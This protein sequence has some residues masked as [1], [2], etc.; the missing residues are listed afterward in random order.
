MVDSQEKIGPNVDIVLTSHQQ[1]FKGRNELVHVGDQEC[2]K[3]SI[4]FK[5]FAGLTFAL[6]E[7]LIVDELDKSIG[8]ILAVLACPQVEEDSSMLA[9]FDRLSDG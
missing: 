8:E 1:S 6:N 5:I 3:K 2:S 7:H 4:N 9:V